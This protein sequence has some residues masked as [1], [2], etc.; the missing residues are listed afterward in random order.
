MEIKVVSLLLLPLLLNII[1]SDT[2]V[3]I[4][5][6][7]LLFIV[8]MMMFFMMMMLF[9]MVLRFFDFLIF[10]LFFFLI[11]GNGLRLLFLLRFL[12]LFFLLT[13]FFGLL[14][15]IGFL[16]LNFFLIVIL[17]FSLSFSSSFRLLALFFAVF[18]IALALWLHFNSRWTILSE[19]LILNGFELVFN[20][21]WIFLDDFHGTFGK[22]LLLLDQSCHICSFIGKYLSFGNLINLLLSFDDLLLG[23]FFIVGQKF[24]N[25][26]IENFLCVVVRFLQFCVHS[27]NLALD[28]HLILL[29]RFWGIYLRGY[30]ANVSRVFDLCS[31]RNLD[32]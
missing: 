15:G 17:F 10:R 3:F 18:S 6:F 5:R 30:Q 31:L 23:Q 24:V 7:F 28:H 20:L 13:F 16:I 11:L 25:L 21:R 32:Q 14:L 4:L 19:E 27:S 12:L 8:V 2:Q 22:I 1:L 26:W 29:K 9:L